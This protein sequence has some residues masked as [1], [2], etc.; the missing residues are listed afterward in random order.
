MCDYCEKEKEYNDYLGVVEK[1][2]GIIDVRTCLY[3]GDNGK[4]EVGTDICENNAFYE[5]IKI[6]FCPMCG[7]NLA[8]DNEVDD[9]K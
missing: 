1:D 5:L 8:M 2:F 3:I 4:L 9:G 6:N 7:R